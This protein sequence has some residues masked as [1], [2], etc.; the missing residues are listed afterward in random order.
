MQWVE[1]YWVG[2]SIFISHNIDKTAF[3][4]RGSD[5]CPLWDLDSSRSLLVDDIRCVLWTQGSST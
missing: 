5:C 4:F 1:G 2:V 3:G